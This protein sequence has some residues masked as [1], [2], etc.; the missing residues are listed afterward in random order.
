MWKGLQSL[1]KVTCSP[2]KTR[3]HNTDTFS[4]TTKLQWIKFFMFF[5]WLIE[6]LSIFSDF[7]VIFH[8]FSHFWPYFRHYGFLFLWL[9]SSFIFYLSYEGSFIPRE[10]ILAE[11]LSNMW[12][13]A[14][15]TTKTFKIIEFSALFLGHILKMGATAEFSSKLNIFFTFDISEGCSFILDT[16][17]HYSKRSVF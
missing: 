7:S 5:S 15:K 12:W 1:S 2:P 14:K 11:L 3:G 6:I 4:P 13:I 9:S 8:H 10:C 17:E 16:D